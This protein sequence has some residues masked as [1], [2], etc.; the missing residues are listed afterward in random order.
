MAYPG[1]GAKV[2]VG[3]T[4]GNHLMDVND[5]TFTVNREIVDI[6][7]F[8][9]SHDGWRD[10]LTNIGDGG[11]SMSGFYNVSDTNGQ[12]VLR[13]AALT[14]N[15]TSGLVVMA[16]TVSGAGFKCDA[17]IESFEISPAIEGAVPF[18]M[19]FQSN[20]EVESV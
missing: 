13:N 4:S 17:F 15:E 11:G 5:A 3:G 7:A 1:K 9:E 20:G 14:G 2:Y 18:T 6:S 16:S 19:S 10:R 8:K 12:V